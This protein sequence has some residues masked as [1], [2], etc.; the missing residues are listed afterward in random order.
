M[1]HS[2]CLLS[3]KKRS[4][5]R[6]LIHDCLFL[7]NVH[8][9]KKFHVPA[10]FTMTSSTKLMTSQGIYMHHSNPIVLKLPCEKFHVSSCSQTKVKIGWGDGGSFAQTEVISIGSL[11][12]RINIR[13]Y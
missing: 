7:P 1:L 13:H 2:V 6:V 11:R 8:I 5:T 10:I 3:E 9:S 4:T 12:M